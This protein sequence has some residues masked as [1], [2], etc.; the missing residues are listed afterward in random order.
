MLVHLILS[1][2][3]LSS[4]LFIPSTLFCS[5]EVISTSLSSTS[6]IHSSASDVLLLIFS[7]VFLISVIVL[8]V[9]VCLF[10]NSFGSLLSDCYIFSIL[11]SRFLIIFTIII[12]NYFS[13]GLPISSSFIWTFVFLVCS[14]ICVVFLCLF[15]IIFLTYCVWSLLFPGFKIGFFLPFGFCPPKVGPVVSVSF[16][17]GEICAEFLF[18]C[19]FFLWWARLSEVV[20]LSADDWVYICLVSCLYEASCTGCY[21]GLCDARS[22]IQ[23]VSFVW[24]LTI[25]HSLG[26]VLW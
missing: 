7:R 17:W 5:S 16:L 13:G 6:L 18:V 24:F 15:I 12:L 19:L 23:L 20:V 3:S 11:F 1:Q 8:F 21:W 22:C 4:V 2:R 9:S 26:L 10:F 25:W 14:F